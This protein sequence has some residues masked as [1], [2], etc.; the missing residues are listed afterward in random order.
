MVYVCV[1]HSTVVSDS[2]HTSQA[3]VNN[4]LPLHFNSHVIFVYMFGW[5]MRGC[6]RR[7][8]GHHYMRYAPS[9]VS[10]FQLALVPLR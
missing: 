9:L 1:G 7:Q 10:Y 2:W 6:L 4:Y 8:T 5:L 3:L